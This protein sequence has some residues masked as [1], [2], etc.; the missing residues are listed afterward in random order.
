[1]EM[2]DKLKKRGNCNGCGNEYRLENEGHTIMTQTYSI[3]E[4][5]GMGGFISLHGSRSYERVR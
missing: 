4:L 2:L 1:M 3:G 5:T